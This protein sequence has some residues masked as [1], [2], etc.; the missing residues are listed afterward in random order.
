[1]YTIVI[2]NFVVAKERGKSAAKLSREYSKYEGIDGDLGDFLMELDDLS[3]SVVSGEK[4]PSKIARSIV[5]DVSH[6]SKP[7]VLSDD[8]QELSDIDYDKM[9]SEPDFNS[10]DDNS[11]SLSGESDYHQEDEGDSG[12][13]N[14]SDSPESQDRGGFEDDED[15]EKDEDEI[16]SETDDVALDSSTFTYQPTRGEDIYGRIIEAETSTVAAKKYIPPGK[17]ALL[18][19]IDEVL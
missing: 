9:D 13:D 14:E 12:D 10:D 19:T 5:A 8:D 17:R 7:H 6:E 15:L 1:M 11:E 4:T 16:D 3:Q 2:F 18:A